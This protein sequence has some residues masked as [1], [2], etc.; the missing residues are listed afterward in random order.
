MSQ[1]QQEVFFIYDGVP[2]PGQAVTVNISGTEFLGTVT[3]II[4]PPA[5]LQ[6]KVHFGGDA[7]WFTN[8]NNGKIWRCTV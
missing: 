6:A 8:R 2:P 7:R 5:L 3:T 1:K 4:T